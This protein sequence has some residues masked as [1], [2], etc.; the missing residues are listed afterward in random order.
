MRWTATV[1]IA[2]MVLLGGAS[3]RAGQD[4]AAKTSV[5]HALSLIG[6]PK[7]G[8]DFTQLDYVNPDAPK[9]GHVRLSAIGGFDSLN[10]YIIKGLPAAGIGLVYET[11]MTSP[12]DQLSADYGLIAESIE[13]PDDLS[14]A[15]FTLRPEARWHDG[16]AITPEDVIF[17]FD[18]LKEKGRPIYRFYYANVVKAEKVG[19]RKVK[20]TFSG[21]RNRELPQ[22]MGQLPVL[23]K[24]WFKDHPF[25]KTSLTPPL[26]SGPYQVKSVDPG[27]AI[28]YERVADYWGRDLPINRGRYNFETVRFDYYRDQTIALEAFKAGRYDYRTEGSSKVWATGYDFPALRDGLVIRAEVPH[29]R[30]T[31]MQ[32]FAINLRREKFQDRALR[33]ALAYAFDFAWSNKHL[34][35]GQYTRTRSYFSNSDLAASGLPSKAELKLLEPYRD[36]LPPEVFTKEY[37]PPESDGSGNIR[38]NLRAALKL[39]RGAGWKIEN[40]RLIDPRTGKP[41]EIEFLLVSPAFERVVMPFIQNLKRLGV[42]ARVRTVDAAQYQNRVRDFDFDIIVASFGQSES[43]GNEQREYWGSETADRPGSRNVIGIKNPVVDALIED[44]IQAPDRKSLITATRALDRVLQWGFYVIPQWH[45][46]YERIAYWD[47]FG[48]PATYP[49][50]GVDLFAWWIEPDKVARLAGRRSGGSGD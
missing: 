39:L 37:K 20:F 48:R 25:D 24:A 6:E 44:L 33:Q 11:L 17:T 28:T 16:G 47:I 21:P 41:L 4:S 14:W 46:R 43:P 29:S 5:S 9:G 12:M 19:P 38:A 34:F 36:Q 40:G 32:G 23:P 15:I 1:A 50:Y 13:V 3:A 42:T 35:Y 45:I 2:L 22:I 26:G 8:P 7:Y 10:P 31:G 27:R 49:K 18:V 30:P